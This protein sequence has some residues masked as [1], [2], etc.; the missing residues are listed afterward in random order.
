MQNLLTVS[1]AIAAFI[2]HP[3]TRISQKAIS[4]FEVLIR[5][6]IQLEPLVID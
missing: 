1:E 4:A 3:E 6:A 5:H 2:V